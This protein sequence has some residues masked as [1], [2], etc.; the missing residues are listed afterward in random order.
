MNEE[1]FTSLADTRYKIETWRQ[2]YNTLRPRSALDD[3][4]PEQFRQE[5]SEDGNL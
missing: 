3:R 1:V 2:D 5:Q 4:T